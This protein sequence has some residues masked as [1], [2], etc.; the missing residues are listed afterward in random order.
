MGL[1][2]ECLL[3]VPLFECAMHIVPMCTRLQGTRPECCPGVHSHATLSPPESLLRQAVILLTCFLR[4][5]SWLLEFCLT[6]P[7]ASP[8]AR[9]REGLTP[10]TS[11]LHFVQGR[12]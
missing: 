7:F 5:A 2:A 4:S 8:S 9:G 3:E 11:D 10:V 6:A 1:L 12:N